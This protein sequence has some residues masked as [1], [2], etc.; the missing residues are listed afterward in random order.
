LWPP[1]D[2][3]A[4]GGVTAT[5]LLKG[6]ALD[7]SWN[8]RGTIWLDRCE[9]SADGATYSGRDWAGRLIRGRKASDRLPPTAAPPS[10]VPLFNGKDLTGWKTHRTQPGNWRV[11]NGILIGSGPGAPTHL[12]TQRGDYQD[13]R[14]RLEARINPGGISSVFCRAP[15][16][17][18][19][20]ANRPR[21]LDGYNFRTDAKTL[22]GLFLDQLA[23]NGQLVRMRDP[24]IP[25]GQWFTLDVTVFE[26][27]IAVYTNGVLTAAYSDGK[28]CFTSGHIALQQ[29]S[30]QT[31]VQLRKI[32]IKEL[33]P[34]E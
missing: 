10:F 3:F 33:V 5:W 31:V 8:V 28:R 25:P 20:P 19:W 1:Q 16:G 4:G 21:W 26:N 15:F 7:L 23:G 12:Y 13:F 17:P 18:T 6:S 24:A 22:G 11:E 29:Q 2:I 32:E 9:L 34:V 27:E 14:V 30:P